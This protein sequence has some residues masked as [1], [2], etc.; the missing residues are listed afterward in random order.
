M[1]LE[2]TFL[3]L[4]R[5]LKPEYEKLKAENSRLNRDVL[6][7]ARRLEEKKDYCKILVEQNTK[8]E[9]EN[10]QENQSLKSEKFA[11]ECKVGMLRQL[12]K[13]VRANIFNELGFHQIFWDCVSAERRN[14]A[15]ID[16]ILRK[17]LRQLL[18]EE[19]IWHTSDIIE[20]LRN[21]LYSTTK[22][23]DTT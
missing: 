17:K 13:A 1:I 20:E 21:L 8:L 7:L 12:E 3:R 23:G 15:H 2:L 9:K 14:P 10:E 11:L 5:K 19:Q 22:Q 18:G 6:G 4:L 16:P